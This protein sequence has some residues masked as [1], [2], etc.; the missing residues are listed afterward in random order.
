MVW[1]ETARTGVVRVTASGDGAR[2]ADSY[3]V[4]WK[5]IEEVTRLRAEFAAAWGRFLDDDPYEFDLTTELDGTGAISVSVDW[6]DDVAAELNGNVA[7][8]AAALRAALDD[9]VRVTERLLTGRTAADQSPALHFP[10]CV[11]ED[12]FVS[13]ID[14]GALRGL[15]PDQMRLVRSLQPFADAGQPGLQMMHDSLIFLH[16][17][18]AAG[19]AVRVLSW[20]HSAAPQLEV[21]PPASLEHLAAEPDGYVELQPVVTRFRLRDHQSGTGGPGAVRGTPNVA[22]D[23]AAHVDPPPAHGDDTL[24]RRTRRMI[25]VVSEVVRSFERSMGLRRDMPG[26]PRPSSDPRL[27]SRPPTTPWRSQAASPLAMTADE[28]EQLLESPLGLATVINAHDMTLLVVTPAGVFERVIPPA[29]SLPAGA[30]RGTA[31]EQV[32]QG[33]AAAWGL[34]DFVFPPVTQAKGTATREIGDGIILTGAHGLVLQSKSREGDLGDEARERRWLDKNMLNAGKQAAGTVR[35]LCRQPV[36]LVNGRGRRL[37]VDGK[38]YSWT[39]VVLIDHPDVPGDVPTPTLSGTLPVVALLR[40]DW[41]FLFDQLRSVHAVAHYLRRVAAGDIAAPLGGEP[42]RYYELAQLDEESAPS[43]IDPALLG[44]DG[45]AETIPL[46]PKHPAG[47]DDEVAH[48]LYRILL[49]DIATSAL[50]TDV[51][52]L[53]RLRVLAELDSLEVGSRSSL[54]RHLITMLEEVADTPSQEVAWRL[55]RIVFGGGRQLCFG[56]CSRF[57][58][59]VQGAFSCWAQLRHHDLQQVT[60]EVENSITVA[61]LLTPRPDGHRR[62]DTTLVAIQGDLELTDEQLT[63]WRRV[64]PT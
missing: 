28:V 15:R 26:P 62:W 20:A 4:C 47:S 59:T 55:R 35:Q 46:L 8:Q 41:E 10:V 32:T 58:D 43:A 30:R 45:I 60:G 29:S 5:G 18:S 1:R 48:G 3:A 21:K 57:D 14:A 34:P 50:D 19:D 31:A 33:V 17:L 11:E 23:A 2:R 7:R 61:V 36:E 39:G 16:N 13:H 12:E 44:R 40:R 27:D 37:R 56:V 42:L 63:A 6:R 38:D 49:E 24:S 51:S 52:E 64:F 22:I 25:A 9:A 54:G 53:E